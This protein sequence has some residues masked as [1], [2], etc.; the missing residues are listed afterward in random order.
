M[1]EERESYRKE[2]VLFG[3]EIEDYLHS[4]QLTTQ[5]NFW[6]FE[7]QFQDFHHMLICGEYLEYRNAERQFLCAR[8]RFSHCNC[9]YSFYAPVV[10]LRV[11]HI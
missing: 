2:F 11:F 1:Q 7:R 8:R 6:Y 5:P 9:G 3:I 4:S 10:G